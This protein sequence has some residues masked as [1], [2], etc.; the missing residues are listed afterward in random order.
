MGKSSSRAATVAAAVLVGAGLVAAPHASARRTPAGVISPAQVATRCYDG[1]NWHETCHISNRGAGNNVLRVTDLYGTVAVGPQGLGADLW[2][3]G[4]NDGQHMRLYNSNG[5]CLTASGTI[6]ANTY[7]KPCDGSAQQ[8]WGYS[9]DDTIF[10]YA[11]G[12]CLTIYTSTTPAYAYTAICQPTAV[13]RAKWF[14]WR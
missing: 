9:S 8:E 5:G 6:G 13:Q 11:S 2:N 3:A 1:E 14:S 7:V 10:H 12:T 4:T